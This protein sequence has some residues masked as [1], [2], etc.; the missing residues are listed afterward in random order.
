MPA[1]DAGGDINDIRLDDIGRSDAALGCG[2]GGRQLPAPNL[3][4]Q[5]GR[6]DRHVERVGPTQHGHGDLAESVLEPGSR[7]AVPLVANDQCR[8]ALERHSVVG[9]RCRSD[10]SE[11][12]SELSST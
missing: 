10:R 6:A 3:V 11:V 12:D 2:L 9:L 5:D 1:P 7:D 8:S 4:Q